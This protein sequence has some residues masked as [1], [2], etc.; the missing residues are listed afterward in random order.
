MS[1]REVPE[2]PS[3]QGVW[4]KFFIGS[5]FASLLPTLFSALLRDQVNSCSFNPKYL[6]LGLPFCH[7][8]TGK[9]TCSEISLLV[10]F[11]KSFALAQ[12]GGIIMILDILNL[13]YVI[14]A[15]GTDIEHNYYTRYSKIYGTGS[16]AP[17]KT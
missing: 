10:N 17:S 4:V 3:A 5:P 8:S 6:S 11:L 15:V 2:V 14:G 13:L 9:V 12:T 1:S 7:L 16:Q